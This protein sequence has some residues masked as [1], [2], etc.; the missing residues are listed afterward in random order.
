MR[1]A[2][3]VA[4]AIAAAFGSR[5]SSPVRKS[6]F[7]SE[8]GHLL[9]IIGGEIEI[10]HAEGTD[11]GKQDEMVLLGYNREYRVMALSQVKLL[12]INF[13]T[14]YHVCDDIQA[15][16]VW[17]SI[18]SVKYQFNTLEMKPAMRRFAESVMYYLEQGACCN[19]LYDAK[20]I[21]I[22]VIY[23]L[24]YP[25]EELARFFYPVLYKDLAFDTLVRRNYEHA[26]TVQELANL[27]GYSLPNFKKLFTKHFDVP[28]YR[29]MLQQKSAKIKNR[30]LDKTVPI[31]AIAAEIRFYRSIAPECLLQAVFQCHSAPD[32][33]SLY[34]QIGSINHGNIRF[35]KSNSCFSQRSVYNVGSMMVRL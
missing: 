8:S 23:R 29:W 31:K 24:F 15:E 13:T 20:A 35:Y 6:I 5:Y 33:E 1:L 30:L 7:D 27:C 4:K 18:R 16:N 12:V 14:H 17:K 9:F 34:R 11:I 2:V 26:K 21:E 28:P 19:H 32:P 25:A 10:V 3:P 22:S